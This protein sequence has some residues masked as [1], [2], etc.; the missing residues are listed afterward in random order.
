MLKNFVCYVKNFGLCP[1]SM[2]EN[3]EKED[4]IKEKMMSSILDIIKIQIPVAYSSEMPSL[5]LQKERKDGDRIFRI[6][7]CIVWDLDKISQR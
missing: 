4:R 5:E 2:I 6:H 1:K 3:T 7:Q